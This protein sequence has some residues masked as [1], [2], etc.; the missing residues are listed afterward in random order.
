MQ[1]PT[2]VWVLYYSGPWKNYLRLRVSYQRAIVLKPDFDE[3]HNNLG[4]VLQQTGRLSAGSASLRKAAQ[5]APDY[6]HRHSNLLF[7]LN[8][9]PDVSS[10]DLFSEYQAFGEAAT[11]ATKHRFDHSDYAPRE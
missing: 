1:K 9:D 8:Y 10:A 4:I 5:L 2:T 7:G 3:A 11:A 6:F